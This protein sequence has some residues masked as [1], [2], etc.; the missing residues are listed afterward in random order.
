MAEKINRRDFLKNMGA[1][2]AA[3]S[4]PGFSTGGKLSTPFRIGRVASES[5]SVYQEASDKSPI[6]FQR[7]RDDILNIYGSVE[8]EDG[9]GYN[10]IW[11]RVWGG[12]VHSAFVQNVRNQLNPV[13]R[14]FP[15]SGQLMEVSVPFTQSFRLRAGGKWESFYKLYY[16]STHWAFEVVEG[17]DGTPWYRIN[18]SLLTLSYY[19]PA[20]HLRPVREDELT[21]IHP[22]VSAK[23]KRIEIS[24]DFQR[25]RAFENDQLVKEFLVSTGKPNILTDPDIIPTDTPRGDHIIRS[26]NPSVH[27]GDGTLRSDAEAYELPGVPWV[28]YFEMRGYAIHGTYWHNN[29]GVT[30]SHGCVNMRSEEAK[31]IYRWSNPVPGTTAFS[32]ASHTIVLVT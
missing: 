19:V 28:S 4:M 10:P 20:T 8:S 3:V 1:G 30:M 29:F 6:R 2:L 13:Q 9:P 24:I 15:S 5:I 21:P 14:E 16:N 7:F 31:W 32:G 22:E 23:S 26:K 17:M 27:M 12:Y 11:H 25:L 18:N